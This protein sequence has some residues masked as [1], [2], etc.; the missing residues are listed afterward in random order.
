MRYL[1]IIGFL[2]LA[3][4]WDAGLGSVD[5]LGKSGEI[6]CYSGGKEIFRDTSTGAVGMFSGGG[7]YYRSVNGKYVQ[8]FADCF[9]FVK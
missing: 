7:W 4:C 9:V 2:F 8:T 3:G 1:L 6:I 5:A